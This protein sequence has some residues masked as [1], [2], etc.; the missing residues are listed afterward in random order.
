MFQNLLIGLNAILIPLLIFSQSATAAPAA[1][2]SIA[3]GL[4]VLQFKAGVSTRYDDN[5]FRQVSGSEEADIINR[6]S[7]G[8]RI[9]AQYS[10]QRL[11]LNAGI[12][13]NQYRTNDRLA[14]E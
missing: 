9:D 5:I 14:L 6:L 2:S 3:D 7:L 10:L 4:D 13:R 11:R 1:M 12:T 8:V